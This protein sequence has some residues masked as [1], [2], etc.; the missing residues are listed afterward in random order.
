MFNPKA[1]A[2]IGA[3]PKEGKAGYSILK[4][5]LKFKGKLYPI[6]PKYSE[7]F[8]IKCYKSILD[9]DDKIDL[10]I[11]VV[12]NVVVPQVLEECGKKGVK[13]VVIIS[14]GFS[15]VG[16]VE[17]ENKVRGILKKY[18]IRA[19]GPNCFGLINAHINLNATFSKVFPEKGNISLI[20]QS[21]AVID[22]ILDILPL[23]NIG[24]SKVVS[25]G[26]KID[27]QESDILEILKDDEETRVI[28]IYLE[29]L[30]DKNFLKVAKEVA[31][32]KPIIVLKAGKS[33]AGKR[34]AKSHTGA[35]AGENELY[36]AIFK[37][38]GFIITETFEEFVDALH[39]FSTQP[40]MRGNK[41]GIITNAGG[42]GVLA[43]DASESY[44][45]ELPEFSVKEE[46]KEV[47]KNA[48]ISNPLDI[49]GDA[50]PER[51]EKVV[52]IVM[53]D[54]N[55]DGY[56]IILTPQ[57]M[58]KPLE[59]A[60][61][62]VRVE[63]VKPLVTSFIGGVSVKGAKS[64]LRK[65][66]IPSYITPENGVKA[67]SNLYKFYKLKMREENEEEIKEILEEFL[68]IKEENK[69][70]I[71]E[72][73]KKG[74]EY[75]IKKLLSLYNFPVP[76]G[77]IVESEEEAEEVAKKLG[78]VVLKALNVYHKTDVGAVIIDPEDVREAYKNLAEKFGNK[79][80]IE[81]YIDER[82]VE[83]I[84]G[85]KRSLYPLFLVGLGGIFTEVLKDVSL[86]IPPVDRNYIREMLNEL[87]GSKLLKGYRG[88]EVD[89]DYLIDLLFKLSIFFYIHDEIREIDLN[90]ILAYKDGA[91]ILDAKIVRGE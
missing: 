71:R 12:P 59:V 5:L 31:K 53:K 55:M 58:T 6:N 37:Q 52:K 79:I 51:Y 22:A 90:P 39:V 91:K 42:F 81:E 54:K 87:K 69:E 57:E 27:I 61:K 63:K 33:E 9:V 17:L 19:I 13:Y 20:S 46:L 38:C 36:E 28:G 89:L 32:K 66:G 83:L 76:R 65:H 80:L 40:E 24:V 23:L 16:N 21:G 15:E 34:A 48:N 70:E 84:F 10:A 82:G 78:R 3:T 60:E 7:I 56:L 35:L 30:K 86:A 77:Y 74:D 47:L 49:I 44:N 73:I 45:L 26:N 68:N 75:S 1:I 18:N 72:L 25:L 64:F 43:A 11:I 14:A 2:I 41:V 29:S 8:G 62:L 50:T 88:I 4:N 67:L 85:G